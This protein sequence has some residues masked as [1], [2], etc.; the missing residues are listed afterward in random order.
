MYFA[1]NPLQALLL[2]VGGGA[3]VAATGFLRAGDYAVASACTTLGIIV[4]LGAGWKM[5][6]TA[7]WGSVDDWRSVGKGLR[8]R[9][10]LLL[11][12]IGTLVVGAGAMW[13]GFGPGSLI[14][15]LLLVG[16]GSALFLCGVVGL[17]AWLRIG[18]RC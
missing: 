16:G 4:L 14:S 7:D 5:I 6:H 1:E 11:V 9:T 13:L 8:E 18:G 10:N 15:G 17:A 3:M 2:L 12:A